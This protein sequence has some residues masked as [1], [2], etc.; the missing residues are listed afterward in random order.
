MT[1]V[2]ASHAR[3]P[4]ERRTN[5]Q[6]S[7]RAHLVAACTALGM[8]GLTACHHVALVAEDG[9]RR[10]V[11][12]DAAQRDQARVEVVVTTGDWQGPERFAEDFAVFHI[13]ITN[14]SNRALRIEAGDFELRDERGHAYT[15]HD[16]GSR[17]VQTEAGQAPPTIPA[18]PARLD[19]DDNGHPVHR[20]YVAD[21]VIAESALAW[22][23][24]PPESRIKGYLYFDPITRTANRADLFWHS[25]DENGQ[26]GTAFGFELY[27]AELRGLEP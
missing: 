8:L 6:T 22:G 25:H 23:V 27:S 1:H 21:A 10:L 15:L 9:S 4:A 3:T 12:R 7:C 5:L 19:S 18:Q 2:R 16:A 26:P 24:L 14:Y 20:M 11:A 13:A 17:F